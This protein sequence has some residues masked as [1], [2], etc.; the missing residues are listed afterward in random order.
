MNPQAFNTEPGRIEGRVILITG[1][2]S[3]IGRCLALGLA[4]LG[5]TVLLLGRD[6]PSLEALYD[7]IKAQDYPEPGIVPFDLSHNDPERLAALKQVISERYGALHG[8]IHNAAILGDR[9]PFEHYKM[10][11]WAEVFRTNFEAPVA[12]TQTLLPL[13]QQSQRSALIFTSSSVGYAPRAYWG[14]YAASK[15]A[16]EGLAT[17]LSE[18]LENTS[19]I[20]VS[21]VNPG[22]TRTKM[23]QAAFPSED[24]ET[25][26]PPEDLVALYAYLLCPNSEAPRG[27]RFESDGS[28]QPLVRSPSD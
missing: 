10:T 7:D 18:E 8:L 24:P 5:A 16:L 14:A 27:Y 9:V 4:Q 23:R 28:H 6:I 26:K 25:V 2:T 19:D 20:R 1:A 11:T 21:V 15:Y 12:M 22:A 13:L 17:L 3:G